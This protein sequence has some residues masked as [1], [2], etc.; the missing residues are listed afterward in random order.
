MGGWGYWG[1][2]GGG[3]VCVCAYLCVD[4]VVCVYVYACMCVCVHVCAC[5]GVG[6]GSKSRPV[7]NWIFNILSTTQGHLR[8]IFCPVKVSRKCL[9]IIFHVSLFPFWVVVNA[10]HSRRFWVSAYALLHIYTY[11]EL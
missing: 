6:R 9:V 11:K 2:G 5:V 4:V 7:S 10:L 3:Y 8:M 1:G